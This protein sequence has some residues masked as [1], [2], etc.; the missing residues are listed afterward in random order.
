MTNRMVQW[1]GIAL[2]LTAACCVE[3]YA[4][5]LRIDPSTAM[6]VVVGFAQATLQASLVLAAIILQGND[7]LRAPM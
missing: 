5:S 1:L 4:H 7:D 6:W 2:L 3:V